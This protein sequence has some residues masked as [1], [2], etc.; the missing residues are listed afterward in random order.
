MTALSTTTTR[1]PPLW[2][3]L[4]TRLP[5]LGMVG[6]VLM[7]AS[8]AAYPV[9]ET[10]AVQRGVRISWDIVGPPCPLTP[11]PPSKAFGRMG[12]KVFR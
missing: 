12:V 2:R 11:G 5:A 7:L 8:I 3:R 1:A 6:V 4:A 10:W 9:Y